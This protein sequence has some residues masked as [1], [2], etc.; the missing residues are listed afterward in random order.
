MRFLRLAAELLLVASTAEAVRPGDLPLT[1]APAVHLN[2]PSPADGVQKRADSPIHWAWFDQ[3][4]DHSKPE[5]GTFKQLYYYSYQDYAG[6]GSPII[7]NSPGE[8]EATGWNGY[9][10]NTT[11][12]GNFAKSVGGA[13]I[14]LEHRY[15][16]YSSP[17][18]NLTTDNLQLLNLDQHLQDLV[19]FAHNVNLTFDPTGSSRPDKAPWV[20]TG[21][22]Y[23]GAVTAWLQALYPGTYWAYHASSAVVEAI[24]DFWHYQEIVYQAMP[25]NCSADYTKIVA[26]VDKVLTTGTDAQ[27]QKLKKKFGFEPLNDVDFALALMDGIWL[28]QNLGFGDQKRNTTDSFHGYC[29]YIE[30]RWPGSDAPQPGPEGVGLCAAVN[31][32]SK[33]YKDLIIPGGCASWR[34]SRWTDKMDLG[35]WVSE[36]ATSPVY[37]DTR[38]N[39][40]QNRQWRWM[41]CNEP[42][43]W[44]FT[45]GA[46]DGRPRMTSK[47]VTVDLWRRQCDLYFPEVNGAKPGLR[48]GRTSEQ[49]N[50]RTGGWGGWVDDTERLMWCDG[51]LDPWRAATVSSPWRPGGPLKSTARAPAWVVPGASHCS[52][53]LL[54]NA[55][56]NAD[57]KKVWDA[58]IEQVSKWVGEFYAVNKKPWPKYN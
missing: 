55:E 22:S 29:D 43:E 46:P 16:G 48:R 27:K 58:E 12:A 41:L 42:F 1:G 38:V 52:D 9:V 31:G 39:N 13:T 32:L 56:A 50:A 24:T 4:L 15:W 5:L 2:A 40:F 49:I 47:L 20:L 26:H 6:P 28:S 3:L 14:L 51:E 34:Y 57:L 17:Y 21:C 45:G 30:N 54:R 10:T 7:M 19:Y 25:K 53:M 8:N 11:L 36:D 23:S 18:A 33:W 44:W 37:R 35:C